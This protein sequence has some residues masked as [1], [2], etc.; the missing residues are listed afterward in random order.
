MNLTLQLPM[1]ADERVDPLC[2]HFGRCGGCQL[3]DV[4]YAQQ[5]RAKQTSLGELLAAVSLAS[6]PAIGLHA[7]EPYGYRNRIRLRVERVEGQL[8]FGYNERA[9]TTFL[10]IGT[11]PIAAPV[12]W[13]TAEALLAAADDDRDAM[14]WLM[15]AS[16]VE[17]FC[18]HD[19]SQIQL[20]LWC[21][22]RTKSLQGSFQRAFHAI[23]RHAP[24]GVRIAGAGAI[25]ADPRTGPT[26][27]TLADAGSPG[28]SYTVGSEMYWITRGGFFQVN[29][30]LL[31]TLVELVTSG[32]SGG[33]AWDLFAGVGLFSRVLA[34]SFAKV[35]AVEANATATSDNRA[36]LARIGVAHQAVESTTL[37]FLRGAVMQRERPELVVLDPPRAGAGAEACE[38][39]VRLAPGCIVYVSCDPTTLARDLAVLG[40]GYRVVEL[41]ML[42]LFPQ[43]A[44][45]ETVT[46]LE[47][48]V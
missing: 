34:R 9:T 5:V 24:A 30:L 44:H 37:D 22:P 41:A 18:N 15:A 12:L 43:T 26:G 21:A 7:G 25:A 23:E 47:R 16:E 17:I 32:R 2:P 42:D 8:R 28:L 39:L 6:L 27:R 40:R 10:P 13:A 19:Q 46:V 38:L 14:F 11:C 36:A 35:V 31:G 33:L 29:R 20:T 4:A 3:Q 48:S 1:L 45:V